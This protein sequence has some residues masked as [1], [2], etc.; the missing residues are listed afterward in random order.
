MKK[1]RQASAS[2]MFVNDNVLTVEAI[3]RKYIYGLCSRLCH[4]KKLWYS[5]YDKQLQCD[6]KSGSTEEMHCMCS[7]L[8]SMH[9]V[10][11]L[12]MHMYYVCAMLWTSSMK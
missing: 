12:C 4:S 9:I 6:L 5:Q 11:M 10:Y 8:L 7:V 1:H 2:E 3:R